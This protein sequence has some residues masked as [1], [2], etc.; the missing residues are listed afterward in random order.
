MSERK[1]NVPS[2]LPHGSDCL[3]DPASS[4]RRTSDY[5]EKFLFDAHKV[6]AILKGDL[7]NGMK[8]DPDVISKLE[9]TIAKYEPSIDPNTPDLSRQISDLKTFGTGHR[10]N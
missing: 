2:K 5:T 1:K 10:D 8:I 6:L 4:R 3:N 7:A 9:E